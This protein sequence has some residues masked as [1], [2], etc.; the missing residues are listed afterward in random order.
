MALCRMAK[1]RATGE[2]AETLRPETLSNIVAVICENRAIGT[3]ALVRRGPTVEGLHR[4]VRNGLAKVKRMQVQNKPQSR[5]AFPVRTSDAGR[6]T[7]ARQYDRPGHRKLSMRLVLVVLFVF[8]V[9]AGG[10]IGAFMLPHA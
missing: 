1:N 10:C 6:K 2:R 3:P 5:A 7:L 9:L 4:L 8:G